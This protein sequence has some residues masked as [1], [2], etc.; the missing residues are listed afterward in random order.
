MILR[1]L[2][3]DN[4]QNICRKLIMLFVHTAIVPGCC[5]RLSSIPEP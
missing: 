2:E 1:I 4:T 5:P 3:N